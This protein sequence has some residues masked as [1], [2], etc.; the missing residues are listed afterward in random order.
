MAST[1]H[2]LKGYNKKTGDG[3]R[4]GPGILAGGYPVR[5]DGARCVI[6]SVGGSQLQTNNI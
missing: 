3:K 4:L 1:Y 2:Y 5:V 6:L